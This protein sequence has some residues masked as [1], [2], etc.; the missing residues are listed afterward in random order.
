[1]SLS[2]TST[3]RTAFVGDDLRWYV[4]A[5]KGVGIE[6]ILITNASPGEEGLKTISKPTELLPLVFPDQ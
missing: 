6:T 1:M 2:R 3:E 5:A 4:L